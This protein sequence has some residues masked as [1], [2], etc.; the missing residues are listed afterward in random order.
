MLL[1]LLGWSN[2]AQAQAISL[3]DLLASPSVA[4]ISYAS[5][6]PHTDNGT[7]GASTAQLVAGGGSFR[8]SG[9]DYYANA[10]KID[11]AAG[12]NI[13]ISHSSSDFDAFL[14]IF[15]ATGSKMAENDDYD[16]SLNSY[17]KFTAGATG[18]YFIVPTTISANKTG[19][20]TLSVIRPVEITAIAADKDSIDVP[21]GVSAQDELYSQVMLTGTH[22]SGTEYF[23]SWRWE[24]N[25]TVGKYVY[26]PNN[27]DLPVG[28]VFADIAAA[29][30]PQVAVVHPALAVDKTITIP[31]SEPLNITVETPVW[32]FT[33]AANAKVDLVVDSL[34]SGEALR[35][36]LLDG[37]KNLLDSWDLHEFWY[38]AEGVLPPGTYYLMFQNTGSAASLTAQVNIESTPVTVYTALNYAS[39]AGTSAA[40]S[41]S[42]TGTQV[43]TPNG[44]VLGTGYSVAVTEGK[45]Y[46]ILFTLNAA[47]NTDMAAMLCLLSGGTLEGNATDWKNDLLNVN[48]TNVSGSTTLTVPFNY[49]AVATGNLRLLCLA[50]FDVDEAAYT[51]TVTEAPASVAYT[52]LAY[53]PVSVGAPASGSFS[54]ADASVLN[55]YWETI[56]AGHSF[57]A[58]AGKRY[59]ITYTL[60]AA[61]KTTIDAGLYLLSGGTF[62]GNATNWNGDL[63]NT[64]GNYLSGVTSMTVSLTYN[65]VT[66]GDVRLLCLADFYTEALT[67][68]LTVTEIPVYTA[69]AYTTVSVG[70]PVNASFSQANSTTV[71][72]PV[73]ETIGAGYSFAAAAGK[74]Y[75]ITYTVNSLTNTNITALLILL[76]DTLRGNETGW[77][78]DDVDGNGN[79]N[80]GTFASVSLTYDAATAGNFR[81]LCLAEFYSEAVSYSIT[82]TEIPVYTAIAYTTVSVGAPVNASFSQAST[83]VLNPALETIGAG[84]SFAAAAD[85]RYRITYTVNSLTNAYMDAVLI[86]LNDTL[87]GDATS[88]NG[89]DLVNDGNGVYP[90]TSTSVSLTYNAAT[91]GNIRLLCLAAFDSEEVF[92]SIKV[93]ELPAPI[94]LTALL[95][96]A[97]TIPYASP[98]SWSQ[99]GVLGG[100][101]SALVEGNSALNFRS[102]GETYYAAAY[103]IEMQANDDFEI[104]HVKIRDIDPYLSLYKLSGTDYVWMAENDDYNGSPNSYITSTSLAA[105]TYYI[106][107]T[108][109]NADETGAYTLSVWNTAE[110]PAPPILSSN[111]QLASLTVNGL[112]ATAGA[113]DPTAY[114]ITVA[115][116]HST[117]TVVAEAA[118]ASSSVEV[119]GVDSLVVGN[120]TVPVKVTAE[121]GSSQIY[122]LTITRSV[123]VFT[124]TFNSSGSAVDPQQVTKGATA[125]QPADPTRTGYTFAGWNNGSTAY[126]FSTAV[127][128]NITLTAQWTADVYTITYNDLNGASN[129]NPATYTIE[130]SAI[131]L[132][133][134]GTRTGYTF[135]GWY[136]N[137]GLTGSAV[138]TIAAG[139]TGNVEFWAKWTAATGPTGP[140][141]V[142]G[143]QVAPV[144]VY[145]NPF[146]GNVHLAGAEGYVLKVIG[147]SGKVEHSQKV[148]S[149]DETISLESLPAGLYFFQVEKSGAVKT[150]KAVKR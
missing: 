41:L 68:T 34:E 2:N 76:N 103:K 6:L 14:Y 42:L 40:G 51:L 19:T 79:S 114:T 85:K 92:Y 127:T 134:P 62:Q 124:V 58:A 63:L 3:S 111:T 32:Q 36:V 141:G 45:N 145:P 146:T 27:D 73:L 138:T 112:S 135:G 102:D 43:A 100:G 24:W 90:G 115:F 121:D 57:T 23:W 10:Y 122:T 75:K 107:A 12:D 70:T 64:A 16:G 125:A 82:V 71:L 150:I 137:S 59:Q 136:N 55:E 80:Y 31:C 148:N 74:R 37:N 38:T 94:T 30:L 47:T 147:V 95:D 21:L 67:Y 69:I 50:Y 39:L 13:E 142:D 87:R 105:G 1:S 128:A 20:Y 129:S 130:S 53:T 143:L 44:A 65:A 35:I 9:G 113:I 77:N 4:T 104:S 139:S 109:F 110:P 89:D 83:T 101:N 56:G 88:W 93:E 123:Q 99:N 5:D 140:T 126:D 8:S 61:T 78:G 108:T 29:N 131:T 49:T 117:A 91:A 72:N 48:G 133:A 132:A 28:Y 17:I 118:E 18:T 54:Q 149:P 26:A 15:S 98:L 97:T 52:A 144:Q 7:F 120:N 106:V 25:E 11:L 66:A 116:E 84:Y 119:W 33:L 46:K 60:N 96:N 86:L 81:L 22:A